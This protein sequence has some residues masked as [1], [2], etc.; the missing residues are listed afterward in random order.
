M[1]KCF[2]LSDRGV[3]VD[4]DY[5]ANEIVIELLHFNDYAPFLGSSHISTR[6]LRQTFPPL[7]KAPGAYNSNAV[8]LCPIVIL[9]HSI[10]YSL[11]KCE[12]VCPRSPMLHTS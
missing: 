1:N 10:G 5:S 8:P 9:G 4:A 3:I 12:K 6:S 2:V 7:S 11:R